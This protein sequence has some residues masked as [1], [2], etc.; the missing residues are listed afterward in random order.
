[1][2][3]SSKLLSADA[4]LLKAATEML[5]ALQLLAKSKLAKENSLMDMIA[6]S[7]RILPGSSEATDG[8]T[9]GQDEGAAR[10]QTLREQML[11]REQVQTSTLAEDMRTS[12]L[13]SI[14][15]HLLAKVG[16]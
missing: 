10:V 9:A 14:C 13:G 1:M 15:K 12:K 7:N 6:G 2:Q 8:A 4:A 11:A 3:A 16:Q 5:H